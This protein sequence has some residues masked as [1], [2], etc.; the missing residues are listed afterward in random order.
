[1]YYP[2][3]A[4]SIIHGRHW[5]E[6]TFLLVCVPLRLFILPWFFEIVLHEKNHMASLIAVLIAAAFVYQST[7]T[8][9]GGGACRD[10]AASW[11]P[12]RPFHAAC[13]AVYALLRWTKVV[14][15]L[16]ST[17]ILLMDVSIGSAFW[18]HHN[19]FRT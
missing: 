8:P 5:C 1:M 19:Y 16:W 12:L 7:K 4:M 15:P 13:Y 14:G 6:W 10:R 17:V 11:H 3:G 9:K 18:V 2:T